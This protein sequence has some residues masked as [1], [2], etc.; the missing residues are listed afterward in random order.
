VQV[1][2]CRLRTALRIGWGCQLDFAYF[3]IAIRYWVAAGFIWAARSGSVA[4]EFRKS[5]RLTD[6]AF[7]G[8]CFALPILPSADLFRPTDPAFAGSA[9]FAVR[10]P[11]GFWVAT[12][13]NSQPRRRPCGVGASRDVGPVRSRIS[14]ASTAPNAKR[15]AFTVDTPA[16]APARLAVHLPSDGFEA[17]YKPLRLMD[18]AQR[19]DKLSPCSDSLLLPRSIPAH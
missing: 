8:F 17:V 6:P 2:S 10:G 5:A 7:G 13:P 14:P 1:V 9:A 12:I 3:N 15:Q 18:Q 16:T 19:H 11:S 4:H